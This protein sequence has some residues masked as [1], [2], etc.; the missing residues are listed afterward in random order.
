MYLTSFTYLIASKFS[1]TVF[2]S[3][4]TSSPQTYTKQTTSNVVQIWEFDKDPEP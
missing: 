1:T 2:L 4:F 3:A